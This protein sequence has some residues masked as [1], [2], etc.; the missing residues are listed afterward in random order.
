MDDRDGR[1]QAGAEG[2]A[3]ELIF[4][5]RLPHPPEKVWRALTEPEHLSAWFPADI[6]GERRVGAPLEFVF[7]E[8]EGPTL[9][10]ELRVFEPCTLLE[11]TWDDEVLRFELAPG[12][13]GGTVLRFVNTF[14]ELGKAARDAT[15]WHVCLDALE[16][17]LDGGTPSP[18]GW[19]E[20]QPRYVAA[21]PPEASTIGPPEGHS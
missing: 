11:F 17:D 10:G 18:G 5:R 12:D 4:T 13:E 1:L 3:W 8:D 14:G 15:G 2:D 16:V 20:I 6:V 19:D 9:P 7:R 21:F